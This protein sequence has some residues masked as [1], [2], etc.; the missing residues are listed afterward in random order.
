[1]PAPAP[2]QMPAPAPTTYRSPFE[3]RDYDS[4]ERRALCLEI[5][6]NERALEEIRA[7]RG[8]MSKTYSPSN[9]STRRVCNDTSDFTTVFVGIALGLG[10]YK[11]THG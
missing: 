5:L 4:P 10:I 1:M 3:P 2:V 7:A 8:I 11:F 9:T 6:A